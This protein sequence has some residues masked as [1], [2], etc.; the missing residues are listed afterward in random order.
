MNKRALLFV[1]ILIIASLLLGACQSSQAE[2][3]AETEAEPVTESVSEDAAESEVEEVVA[4]P[5][6]I[7]FWHQY[8]SANAEMMAELVDEFNAANA[9]ILV[10]AV[11]QPSYDEYKT[12]LQ[13]AILSDT[14]PDV[15][16]VDLIWVPGLVNNE[17]VQALDGIIAADSSFDIDDFYSLLVG[18][19]VIDSSR[20]AVPVSANN[21][22]V[23]W[24]KDLFTAA[25]L[26]PET[27]PTTWDE[28]Q[29]MAEQCSNAADGVVGFE[30]Y[31]Q[32]TGEGIT[33]Q[34]QVWLWAAGG[35]FLNAD[36][37]A[38]A[39]N[40]PEGINALTYVSNM[41]NGHGAVPAAWGAFGDGK[42]CMQLD[43]SWL[44]GYRKDAAFDWAIAAVPGP[45]VGQTASNIGGEH[46]I[47]FKNSE[48]QEAV[49]RFMSFLSSTETQL[50][51]DM[52]TG[53]MPIRKSVGENSDYLTWVN[54]TEPRMLP[55]VEGMSAAHTRPATPYYN[56]ISDAFSREIQKA[57]LGET[58][59]EDALASAEEAVN[60]VLDQ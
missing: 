35:E 5:V 2:P 7:I 56:E 13:T 49:W 20:Y 23:I 14:T 43:G 36:N 32:P 58:T 37:S 4:G 10:T 39:F 57:M 29:A 45:E 11:V 15:A 18:Y 54:E 40:T 25:G 50:K 26:D 52:A 1:A 21:M 41:L 9:D 8:D 48:N 22:Q 55:F 19:D 60:V 53:F 28:M 46:L 31:T 51:W 27:P 59:P 24:N 42:A 16:A 34:F 44:F 30:Y 12:L 33:W 3:T 38:A 47:M 17:A 6:E